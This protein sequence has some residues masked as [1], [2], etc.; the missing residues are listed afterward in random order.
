MPPPYDVFI[1]Y[2]SDYKPW[3]EA[4]AR[5]LQAQGLSVWFDDWRKVAGDRV[6]LTLEVGIQQA[7]D[8]ILIVTPEAAESGWVQ[9]EYDTMRR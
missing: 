2:K 9:K 8:G 1:S 6:T 4:L 7:R 3:V 5:N